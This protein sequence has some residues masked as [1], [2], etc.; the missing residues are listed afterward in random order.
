[1]SRRR[2]GLGKGGAKRHRRVMRDN[3]QGITK[4]VVCHLARR[5]GV[6][7]ISSLIYEE[8][9]GV[10]KIFLENVIRDAIT[11]AEHDHRKIVTAMDVVYGLNLPNSSLNRSDSSDDIQDQWIRPD[12]QVMSSLSTT[13]G[14]KSHNKKMSQVFLSTDDTSEQH[15]SSLNR[16]NSSHDIQDQWI[17]PDLQVMFALS[18]TPGTSLGPLQVKSSTRDMQLFIVHGKVPAVKESQGPKSTGPATQKTLKRDLINS[19]G[20]DIMKLETRDVDD[21]NVVRT[22]IAPQT[23]REDGSGPLVVGLNMKN[24]FPQELLNLRPD[25]A[26]GMRFGRSGKTPD[27]PW[28]S[29]TRAGPNQ[30]TICGVPYRYDA[31]QLRIVCACHD[32]H[33]SRNEF[34]LH[35]NIAEASN[36]EK[37]IMANPYVLGSE[38][39]SA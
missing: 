32:R 3:I 37:N 28:V 30:R 10:L 26:C 35:V 9:R 23:I 29:K 18:T 4:P 16:S 22:G 31:S 6:K 2:K 17:R 27:L 24:A 38:A 7:R 5:R 15:N 39:T 12:L 19:S 11:Y 34:V 20:I 25:I 33:M 14:V 21:S 36:P 13:P 8:T 1:M